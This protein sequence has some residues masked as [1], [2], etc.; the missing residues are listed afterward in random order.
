MV[1][2]LRGPVPTRIKVQIQTMMCEEGYPQLIATGFSLT[3]TIQG[4]AFGA[5]LRG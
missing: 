1:I 2:Q 3:N 5:G 4:K